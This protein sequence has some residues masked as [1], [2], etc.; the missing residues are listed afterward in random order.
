M[1]KEKDVMVNQ[2]EARLQKAFVKFDTIEYQQKTMMQKS[3]WTT[4][5][6]IILETMLNNI[7][8]LLKKVTMANTQ[9]INRHK[10]IAFTQYK[11]DEENRGMKRNKVQLDEGY[12]KI[13]DWEKAY[14]EEINAFTKLRARV[15]IME[16]GFN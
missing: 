5:R 16:F 7:M 14:I 2:Q 6:R 8:T 10:Q 11:L 4:S 15:V 1:I 12:N 9:L 13:K 3:R